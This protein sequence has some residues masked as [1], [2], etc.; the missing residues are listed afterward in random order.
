LLLLAP[1]M[2]L[3]GVRFDAAWLQYVGLESSPV[4]LLPSK[5]WTRF[6]T[7]T[8]PLFQ[9]ELRWRAIGLFALLVILLFSIVGFNVA[10]SYVL[11]NFMTAI[12]ERQG[13][14]FLMLALLYAC[15]FAGSTLVAGFKQFTEETLALLW[16][17]WLTKHLT[18][19]YLARRSY[20]WLKSRGDIDNPDQRIAED[21]KTFTTT[22][23]SM[24]LLF[25]SSVFTICGFAGV[26]WLITP[27]LLFAA[28]GY[29]ILGTLVAVVI[30][31]R[32]VGLDV[33]QLKREADLRYELIRVRDHAEPVA[34]LRGE[35]HEHARL[36]GR[37]GE[38]V[39]NQKR[40]IG[41]NRNLS[42]FT[43]GYKYLIQLIPVLIA[44]PLY[45]SGEIEFGVV[46]QATMAFTLIMD[47]FSVV[48][49][50]FQRVTSFAA[51]ITRLGCVWEA[52][53]AVSEPMQSPIQVLDGRSRLQ[54]ESLTL[55]TP[56][57]DRVLIKDL[58][59]KVRSGQRLLIIGP[60]GAGRT[61]LL[62]ATAGLWTAGE[63]RI[64]RPAGKDAVFL[65]QQPYLVPGTLREQ[66]LYA[67]PDHPIS[68][69]EILRV[70]RA[71][72]FGPILERVGGLDAEQ[73]WSNILPLSEQQR[74]TF[75]RLLLT[76]PRFAFLDEATSNLDEPCGCLLYRALSQTDMTY[77]S[78][79]TDRG[80]LDY[81]DILL[82][83]EGDGAWRTELRP[84]VVK[85]RLGYPT[86]GPG[87]CTLV[88]K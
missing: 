63:G 74:L 46:T 55:V 61:T 69:E 36:S 29:T 34:L 48:I 58:S 32:L 87:G 31:G 38:V 59:L 83:L 33:L 42:F 43:N 25:L 84:S 77:I 24:V 16:R 10:N 3:K 35:P 39:G 11:R 49:T 85:A 79:A 19:R 64:I 1:E 65:P 44:A 51:V 14:R 13:T 7:I 17:K 78:V 67:V 50:E 28:V 6:V 30:G 41:I 76:K 80:L 22:A 47:A 23:L 8:R 88:A 54:Y 70:L 82:E 56:Q 27:W 53:D 37:L 66:L 5:T 20:Y 86:S 2:R 12:A 71:V 81:H 15:V 26:L 72:Q 75:A 60:N 57:R 9:S 18:A 45:I 52:L 62:R 4:N 68:D 21:V 73:D 40:I